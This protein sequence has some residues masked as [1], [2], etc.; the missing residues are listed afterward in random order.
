MQLLSWFN[1][2]KE[3][4]AFV[5]Q[6]ALASEGDP[7]ENKHLRAEEIRSSDVFLHGRSGAVR[8]VAQACGDHA[9]WVHVGGRGAAA[10]GRGPR[11]PVLE[12]PAGSRGGPFDTLPQLRVR[13]LAPIDKSLSLY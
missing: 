12:G 1:T 11:L 2:H 10:A 9:G 3:W 13:P 8:A 6:K 5:S 7:W 4:D